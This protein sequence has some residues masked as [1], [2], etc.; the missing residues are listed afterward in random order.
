MNRSKIKSDGTTP[1]LCRI[2]VDNKYT[3]LKTGIY[4]KPNAWDSKKGKV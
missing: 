1:I 3:V 2:T 4:C